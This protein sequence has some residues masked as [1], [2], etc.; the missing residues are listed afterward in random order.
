MH[1]E[2]PETSADAAEFVERSLA[3]RPDLIIHKGDLPATARALRRVFI[4]AKRHFDRDGP[5]KL[6]EPPGRAPVKAVKLTVS[7]IV[8]EA[9]G[10]CRPV[11]YDEA[12]VL[13]P[14][15]LP[16]RVARMFLEMT[17]EWGLRPLDG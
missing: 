13:I 12:G 11:Q 4:S 7:N 10:L 5:V 9:H 16:D 3:G 1:D 8:M 17:G 14:W 2:M 6:V 15:T